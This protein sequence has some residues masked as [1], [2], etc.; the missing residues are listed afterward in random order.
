MEARLAGAGVGAGRERHAMQW[1]LERTVDV[2]PG[3]RVEV[4]F[5]VK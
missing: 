3:K 5:M 2:P 4:E 1:K